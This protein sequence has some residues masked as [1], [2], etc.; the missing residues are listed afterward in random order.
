MKIQKKRYKVFQIPKNNGKYRTVYSVD[1][2]V[3]DRLRLILPLLQK[4]KDNLDATNINYAFENGRNCVMG[5]SQHQG[6]N[7]SLSMDL[8]NF[9]DSVNREHV[10]DLISGN[11][12]ENCLIDDSPRQGLPTSPL[13]ATIAFLKFDYLI[14]KALKRLSENVVYTRYADDLTFSFNDPTNNKLIQKIV[15]EI[16]QD[17]GFALNRKKTKFQNKSN[18]RI[19]INGVSLGNGKVRPTRKTLKKIR[20]ARH[21]NNK[22]SLRGLLEWAKCKEPKAGA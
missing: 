2:E 16:L 13:I 4:I 9:F 18:G 1:Q 22:D 21:Q 5:A 6:N 20:A 15:E 17:S 19:V 14:V 3:K 11:I 12:L 7:Y 8:V 10:R